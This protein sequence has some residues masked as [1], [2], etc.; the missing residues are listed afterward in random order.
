MPPCLQGGIFFCHS[1]LYY[2]NRG[3]L[4]KMFSNGN[5]LYAVKNNIF[6]VPIF[7]TRMCLCKTNMK[8]FFKTD[9]FGF[10]V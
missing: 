7:E 9:P 8:M 1:L 3:I 10:K 5:N 4:K 2:L 6:N